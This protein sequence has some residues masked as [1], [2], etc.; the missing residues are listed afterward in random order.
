MYYLK[1]QRQE[2]KAAQMRGR[3]MSRARQNTHMSRQNSNFDFRTSQMIIETQ[4][5]VDEKVG[6]SP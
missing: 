3:L 6:F 2:I 5:N 4:S 1:F